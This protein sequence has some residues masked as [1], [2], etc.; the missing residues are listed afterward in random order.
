M[1]IV[2][3]IRSFISSDTYASL[4]AEAEYN[5]NA[6]ELLESINLSVASLIFF[7]ENNIDSR[8]QREAENLNKTF[9]YITEIYEQN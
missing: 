1:N 9:Q 5:D 4:A 8:V 3:T 7:K 2:D 6:V